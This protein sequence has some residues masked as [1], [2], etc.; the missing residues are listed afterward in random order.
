[1]VPCGGLLAH[2]GDGHVFGGPD[3]FHSGGRLYDPGDHHGSLAVLAGPGNR[4]DLANRDL[5]RDHDLGL[6]PDGHTEGQA[7]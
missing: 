4:G 1:M 5:G 3:D 2:Q 7:C 6:D